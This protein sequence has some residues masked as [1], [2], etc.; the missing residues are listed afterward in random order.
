MIPRVYSPHVY[1][2]FRMVTGFLFIFHGLQKIFGMYGGN[3]GEFPTQRWLAGMLEL[4]LGGLI[5]V[6]LFTA[7]AAF[8]A[9]GEMAVAY[10]QNHQPRGALPIENGGELAAL[11]C[12]AFL[13]IASYGPGP[14]SIDA[15]RGGKR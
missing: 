5:L 14:W 7:I 8:V 10:F 4:G 12:F 13:F 6:G 15:L 11:Y 2:I 3:V 1:S 9:S